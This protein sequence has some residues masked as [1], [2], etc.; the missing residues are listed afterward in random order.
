MDLVYAQRATLLCSG[1]TELIRLI[2]VCP[3]SAVCPEPAAETAS[4]STQDVFPW[5]PRSVSRILRA[6]VAAEAVGYWW[7]YS[8]RC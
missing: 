8:K 6:Q 2:F 1:L 7:V 4:R 3:E 5:H